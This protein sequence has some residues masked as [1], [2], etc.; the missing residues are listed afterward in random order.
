MKPAR[1]AS[2]QVKGERRPLL[3]R[4]HGVRVAFLA[5]TEM[6]NGI[7]LPH[8]WSVNLARARRIVRDSFP[9]KHHEPSTADR[10]AW[11]AG[12]ERLRSF[13]KTSY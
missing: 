10:A 6:T 13:A 9:V 5:Y 4:T 2:V 12:Y 11:D 8:P 3:L 7:P 1:G